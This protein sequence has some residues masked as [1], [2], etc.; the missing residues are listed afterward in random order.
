MKWL[1]CKKR[2]DKHQLSPSY[3]IFVLHVV[4]KARYSG[5]LHEA[6]SDKLKAG[7]SEGPAGQT[8]GRVRATFSDRLVA[9]GMAGSE[10]WDF[11]GEPGDYREPGG[12]RQPDPVLPG[13]KHRGMRMG[14]WF[15]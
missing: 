7:G 6:L 5:L 14:D 9:D 2:E 3:F 1:F 13:P 10:G 15:R 4:L 12:D 8:G 11:S